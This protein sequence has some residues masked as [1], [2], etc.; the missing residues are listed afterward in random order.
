MPQAGVAMLPV[1]PSTQASGES[2]AARGA[3]RVV[4]VPVLGTTMGATYSV[5]LSSITTNELAHHTLKLTMT[6]VDAGFG[7]KR[8]ESFPA[9]AIEAE[10]LHV[11][12]FYGYGIWGAPEACALREGEAMRCRFAGTLNEMQQRA[13]AATI[14]Q[15][16]AAPHGA[17]LVLPC[18]YGK[19]V[20]ALYVLQ[21]LGRRTLVLVHKAFLVSQWQERIRHFLPEATVGIIQQNTVDADADVVVGMVQSVSKRV[22]EASVM[23]RF[24]T[25]VVDEAHHMSAPVF[26]QALRKLHAKN[27]LGLTATLERKDGL[28]RLLHYSMGDVAHRIERM[29]EET[30]VSYM[31]YEDGY[32]G[33]FT[34]RNGKMCLPRMLN[35][36]AADRRRNRFIAGHIARYLENGRFVIVLSDRIAQLRDL[37]ELA[38][39]AGVD[40]RDISFYIGCTSPSDREHASKQRCILSTYSM[41]KEGL[42]IPRLDTL[43]M[44][45]PKGDVVQASGRVQRKHPEKNIPLIVDVVDPFSIFEKLKWK[46]H[47]FYKKQGFTCQT[48]AIDRD[49][50]WF[51]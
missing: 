2:L 43:V 42:D 36:L 18:G 40:D 6:P 31:V 49:A 13:T 32:R 10:R 15:L 27:V 37:M 30:M 16:E 14:A 12:R 8:T 46:R 28:T 29:P 24:G 5:P 23:D 1:S 35:A 45:T 17:M 3:A 9:F 44:A 25:I 4:S 51:D 20:C 33:E 41:A 7:D 47:S 11:P 21:K 19:T 50:P 39:N 34:Q 48:Y 22:Y 38:V 26:S